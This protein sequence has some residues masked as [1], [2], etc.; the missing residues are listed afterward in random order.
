MAD[1]PGLRW[2]SLQTPLLPGVTVAEVTEA[3]AGSA[4]TGRKKEPDRGSR[5]T[6]P[7]FFS[8]RKSRIH[9]RI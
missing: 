2:S 5:L 4:V 7:P 3:W 1:V 9:L 8:C 6:T